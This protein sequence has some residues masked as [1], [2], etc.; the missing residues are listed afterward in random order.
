M[1][2]VLLALAVTTSAAKG[3]GEGR[4]QRVNS[5]NIYTVL[6]GNARKEFDK[7]SEQAKY[8]ALTSLDE[9]IITV[10]DE[11]ELHFNERG[12][13]YFV[14]KFVPPDSDKELGLAEDIGGSRRGNGTRRRRR[15]ISDKPPDYITSNGG[16]FR[17]SDGRDI[18]CSV[19]ATLTA[20]FFATLTAVFFL[21]PRA[22]L[23]PE[24]PPPHNIHRSAYYA[25]QARL[26]QRHLSGFRRR[27]A[28]QQRLG[29]IL[30]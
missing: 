30:Q 20:L 27:F 4:P 11:G 5:D 15:A 6:G 23:T 22:L 21:A 10:A 12:N 24:P 7:L 2:A 29:L 16:H 26:A 18:K 28:E 25:L 1:L 19:D 8:T 9:H 17:K 14:D 13:M 3:K